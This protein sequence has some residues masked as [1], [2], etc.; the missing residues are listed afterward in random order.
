MTFLCFVDASILLPQTL[1][2]YTLC[3]L[4]SSFAPIILT[5]STR[6]CLTVGQK[7]YKKVKQPMRSS[8]TGGQLDA[9]PVSA[10]SRLAA[11]C[12]CIICLTTALLKLN[13]CTRLV[14]NNRN[15]CANAHIKHGL[16]KNYCI[17]SSAN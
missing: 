4:T 3:Y 13:L 10:Q 14:K 17:V 8:F 6:G 1:E 16:L 7:S 12:T 9:S 15:L 2:L 11:Q 5:I